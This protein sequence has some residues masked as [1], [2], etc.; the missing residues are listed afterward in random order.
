MVLFEGNKLPFENESFAAVFCTEVLKH[1][2]RPEG[3]IEEMH[4]VMRQD[5]RAFVTLPWSARFHYAPHDY[6]RYT[7]S[8]LRLMFRRQD[9]IIPGRPCVVERLADVGVLRRESSGNRQQLLPCL[10]ANG[11]ERTNCT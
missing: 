11:R 2:E 1:L 10:N 8:K 7:P 6:G 4:R 3:L 5:G 9:V